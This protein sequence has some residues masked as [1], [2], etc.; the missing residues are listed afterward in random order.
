MG[1]VSGASVEEARHLAREGA[2]ELSAARKDHAARQ[3]SP[4]QRNL[5]MISKSLGQAVTADYIIQS[6][7]LALFVHYHIC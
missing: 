1:R 6:S 4:A 7:W 3:L 5:R 2:F